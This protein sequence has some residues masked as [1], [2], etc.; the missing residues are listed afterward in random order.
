LAKRIDDMDRMTSRAYSACRVGH[1]QWH[2]H[3]TGGQ[4]IIPLDDQ[5]GIDKNN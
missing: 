4:G 5:I 3:N 1:A 2:I